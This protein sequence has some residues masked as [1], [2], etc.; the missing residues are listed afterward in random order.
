MCSPPRPYQKC[1]HLTTP[2]N[3]TP[4]AAMQT[5]VTCPRLS[6]IRI[7][8]FGALTGYSGLDKDIVPKNLKSASLNSTVLT[9]KSPQTSIL[10]FTRHPICSPLGLVSPA[11]QQQIENHPSLSY[12]T[13]ESQSTT[14]STRRQHTSNTRPLTL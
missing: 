7:L 3:K 9:E 12:P 13:R 5:C 2:S 14:A 1:R 11:A 10:Q 6:T 4:I 8:L